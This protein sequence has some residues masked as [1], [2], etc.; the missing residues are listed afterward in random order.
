MKNIEINLF[1]ERTPSSD[2]LV[3]DHGKWMKDETERLVN[4]INEYL[5]TEGVDML[6]ALPWT[7]IAK[8][9]K[10][11]NWN[12]C[13]KKWQVVCN[14]YYCFRMQQ[15][16]GCPLNGLKPIYLRQL[17]NNYFLLKLLKGILLA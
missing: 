6:N 11:R 8:K 4:F 10:T 1:H 14:I 7:A 5:T 9:V 2:W 16:D 3:L 15:A 13:L 17:D 12:Q